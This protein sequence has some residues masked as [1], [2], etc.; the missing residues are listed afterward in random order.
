MQS[1]GR[2]LVTADKGFADVR[3]HPPGAHAGILLLRP[4]ADGIGAVIELLET[5][6]ATCALESLSGSVAVATLRGLRV[7][8]SPATATMDPEA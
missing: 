5:T 7:R 3:T 2:F 8:R 1:E 6:L 4:D